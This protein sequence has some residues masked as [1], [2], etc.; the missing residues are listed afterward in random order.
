MEIIADLGYDCFALT[1][2]HL[3]LN[4]FAP[5]YPR[6][7]RNFH[8]DLKYFTFA[9]VIETGARFLLD[10]YAKHQPTLVSQRAA[11]RRIRQEVLARAVDVAA[12]TGFDLVSFWSGTPTDETGPQAWMRRLVDACKELCDYAAAKQVRLAFEPAP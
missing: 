12:D 7:L 11:R 8:V 6:Q 10:P 2:D 3:A 1:L 9:G 5:D 4:P